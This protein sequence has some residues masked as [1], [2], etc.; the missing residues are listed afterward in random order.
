MANGKGFAAIQDA[1]PPADS[2]LPETPPAWQGGQHPVYDSQD[3]EHP[4]TGHAHLMH[5]IGSSV[6][7]ML[8][9]DPE[10]LKNLLNSLTGP[11]IDY[12]GESKRLRGLIEA[13]KTPAHPNWLAA[14]VGSWA[15]GPQVAGK[16][17]QLEQRA[18]GAEEQKQQDILSAQ[19]KL[20]S[21]HAEDLRAKGR[22]GEALI[23]GLASGAI[24]QNIEGMKQSGAMERAEFNAQ[25]R[26]D[27]QDR[28]LGA[29]E[30]RV[31]VRIQGQAQIKDKD[32]TQEDVMRMYE[33]LLKQSTRDVTGATQPRYTAE[34]A[35][36]M[37]L[38]TILPQV[39][40]GVKTVKTGK[41]PVE[42]AAPAAPAKPQSKFA[43]WKAQQ[44]T[45]K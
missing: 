42:A 33:A 25:T 10:A 9:N 16:F 19:E 13:R 21:E 37:A 2:G 18:T 7:E 22:T 28:A 32:R 20:I 29:A 26:K 11:G 1:T 3:G 34:Q 6:Q 8:G 5:D 36:D 31:R 23:M 14:G 17:Q 35:M 39:Q 12:E 44:A 30:E 45:G 41:A 27:L 38:K 15:G 43:Q 40:P 24:R 4:D